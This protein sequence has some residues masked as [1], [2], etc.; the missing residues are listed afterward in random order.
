MCPLVGTI[1][2]VDDASVLVATVGQNARLK[3]AWKHW[4]IS[5]AS[6]TDL[7]TNQL[8]CNECFDA[9]DRA[10]L[11]QQMPG[12]LCSVQEV[13]NIPVHPFSIEHNDHDGD[14]KLPHL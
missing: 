10:Q 12:S 7:N 8:A 6:M 1:Y 11:P 14:A 9:I 4:S 13:C 5:A 2:N 3:A